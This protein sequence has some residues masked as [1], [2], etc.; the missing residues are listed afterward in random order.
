M[1]V[2]QSTDSKFSVPLRI[3]NDFNWH[4]NT[5]L[6]AI[7]RGCDNP[8]KNVRYLRYRATRE[9]VPS[10]SGAL[11]NPLKY[12]VDYYDVGEQTEVTCHFGSIHIK[13]FMAHAVQ[14]QFE[15]AKD[16]D[17]IPYR[18][19]ELLIE[20]EVPMLAENPSLMVALCDASLMNYHPAHL[21][22]DA[23][24]RMKTNPDSTPKDVESVY[25]FAYDNL[26]PEKCDSFDSL[27][28]ETAND[29]VQHFRDSLGADIFRS[30]VTWFE[31]LIAGAG[32]LRLNDRGFFTRLVTSP[33]LFSSTF[34]KVVN[35][36]GT[37]FITNSESKGY[38][39]PPERLNGMSIQ[40]Y[41]PKVFQA[42]SYTYGGRIACSLHDFC[43][44][45]PQINRTNSDCLNKP[46][47]RVELPKLC[48]YA[49]MWKT[50]GLKGKTP[51]PSSGS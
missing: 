31:E 42:I 5:T 25:A 48:P 49:Q 40:P 18:L 4:T 1:Q 41:Y 37:P 3:H 7:Y 26:R 35:A 39:L 27:F 23:I 28:E 16:H 6:K 45:D 2:R 22:F 46:W 29:A 8:V 34:T 9:S 11:I 44:A 24:E 20:C 30:N 19:V 32:K 50:W 33:G 43:E 51:R 14:K 21:F 10:S 13:E 38:F 47:A 12:H 15:P 36:L 17:D